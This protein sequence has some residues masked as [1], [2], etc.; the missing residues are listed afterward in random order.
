MCGWVI[1]SPGL[2]DLVVFKFSLFLPSS[3]PSQSGSL[4]V[5]IILFSFLL[6]SSWDVPF[7]PSY[8]RHLLCLSL[9][10]C[11]CQWPFTFWQV[12]LFTGFKWMT[13]VIVLLIWISVSVFHCTFFH[14]Y[15]LSAVSCSPS[16]PL[17]FYSVVNWCMVSRYPESCGISD[18]STLPQKHISTLSSV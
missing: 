2:S 5:S 14:F 7:T 9:C 3:S 10:V 16:F 17:I 1:A 12:I 8:H 15:L 4:I 18:V 6:C 13:S 11:V